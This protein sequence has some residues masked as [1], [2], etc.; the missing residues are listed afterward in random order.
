MPTS[1]GG[2]GGGGMSYSSRR[3]TGRPL[4]ATP[5]DTRLLSKR[6]P[7]GGSPLYSS[8]HQSSS[9]YGA[10]ATQTVSQRTK[11]M[12]TPNYTDYTSP[13]TKITRGYDLDTNNNYS[14][15]GRSH[16]YTTN[17]R[18]SDYIYNTP[19][20]KAYGSHYEREKYDQPKNETTNRY[21][22]T[23]SSQLT[24]KYGS[25]DR[26]SSQSLKPSYTVS[27]YHGSLSKLSSRS[28]SVDSIKSNSTP[29]RRERERDSLATQNRNESCS[30]FDPDTAVVS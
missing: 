25:T 13:S 26:I 12:L 6:S 1:S 21:S 10:G 23:A 19:S 28:N 7:A 29:T 16:A 4:P 27:G 14:S 3:T 22:S 9:L 18:G 11:Q 24:N 17:N 5:I 30:S 15:S 20:S 2:G 8:R